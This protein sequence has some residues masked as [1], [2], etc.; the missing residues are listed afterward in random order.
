MQDSK[1]R[2]LFVTYGGLSIYDGTRFV[3]YGE[4]DGLANELVNDVV[5]IT[6][7]SFLVATNVRKLNTLAQGRIG[8]LKTTDQFYPT[9]NHFLKASD[10]NLYVAADEGLFLL[11]GKKFFH[12]PLLNQDG[13]DVGR[14]FDKILEWRNYLFLIP[15]SAIKER[16][17]V[18]DKERKKHF[19]NFHR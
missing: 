1:G 16:L 13:S 19:Y 9:V 8:L 18:Y 12:L 11:R 6:P 14:N 10:G 5:E 15:W 2:M 3:N 17:F 4:Q 7:D